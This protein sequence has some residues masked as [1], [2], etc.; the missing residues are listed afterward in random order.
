MKFRFIE[1]HQAQFSVGRM[2]QVLGVSSSGFYA[3]LKRTVSQRERNNEVLLQRIREIFERSRQRYGSPRIHAELWA[4][5]WRIGRKRVASL[6]RLH[7]IRA[8]RKQGYGRRRR[9]PISGSAA[10]NLLQ[11][12]FTAQHVN[13][14]WLADIVQIRTGEGWLYLAVVL[15]TFSRRIVGWSMK[16]KADSQLATDALKMALGQRPIER[17][18][19]HHSDRGSQYTSKEYRQLLEDHHIQVSMSA[20]GNC[21]DNAMMESF[22]ATLK[23]EYSHR[24]IA[25]VQEARQAVFDFIEIWYNRQRR[26][27][28]LGFLSP[29]QYERAAD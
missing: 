16:Q 21:Y 27:S 28:A 26:H 20:A 11:Q 5:G 9:S 13:Q 7:G 23:T 22:F 10:A 3:W 24:R 1:S 6:M 29:E 12:D 18:M 17:D 19:V 4:A 25:T 2:C 15:D 14:K 8:R